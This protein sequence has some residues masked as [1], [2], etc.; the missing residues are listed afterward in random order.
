LRGFSEVDLLRGF[1]E[2]LHLS[3]VPIA[4]ERRGV[5]FGQPVRSC[6]FLDP[7]AV[8]L[9]SFAHALSLRWSRS[10]A[11]LHADASRRDV[12]SWP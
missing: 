12:R 2:R 9:R 11:S 6:P 3:G 10:A 8:G 5:L 1:C 7:Y 4:R